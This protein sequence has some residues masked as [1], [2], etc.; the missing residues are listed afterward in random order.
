MGTSG[1]G[2][3][4]QRDRELTLVVGSLRVPEV[5]VKVAG[6]LVVG[7]EMYMLSRVKGLGLREGL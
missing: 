7:A 5:V 1:W 4:L 6:T 3:T 2:L